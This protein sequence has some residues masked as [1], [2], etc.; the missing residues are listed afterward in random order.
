MVY[1][2]CC[3]NVL[4]LVEA[5]CCCDGDLRM[6]LPILMLTDI[7]YFRNKGL[8]RLYLIKVDSVIDIVV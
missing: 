8:V 3:V 4:I 2:A 1:S 5:I 6:I 7:L